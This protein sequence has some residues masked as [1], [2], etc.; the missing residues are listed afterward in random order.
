MKHLI[1]TLVVFTVFAVNALFAEL[2][3]RIEYINSEEY[4][5]TISSIARWE[6][7]GANEKFRLV[8]LDGTVLVE[9]NLYDDIRRIVIFDDNEGNAV[10]TEDNLLSVSV[11]PNPTQEMLYVDGINAG[12]TI[13]IF[14][15][16]GQMLLSSTADNGTISL[17][18]ESLSNGVYLLQIGTEIVKFIKQ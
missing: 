2:A 14:S 11:F 16:D 17:S 1:S 6:I 3:M 12:E 13:R 5:A 7:D 18:V 9:R 10:K 8:A 4:Q 15:L